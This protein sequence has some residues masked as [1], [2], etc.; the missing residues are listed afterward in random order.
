MNSYEVN[1][2]VRPSGFTVYRF[3]LHTDSIQPKDAE[4]THYLRVRSFSENFQKLKY[5][6]SRATCLFVFFTESEKAIWSVKACPRILCLV[7]AALK[8][9]LDCD[10]WS[11]RFQKVFDPPRRRLLIGRLKR[12]K[13][14]WMVTAVDSS[15]GDW[16]YSPILFCWLSKMTFW[17]VSKKGWGYNA[18]RLYYCWEWNLSNYVTLGDLILCGV[19]KERA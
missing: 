3:S 8:L 1:M 14:H 12:R 6:P 16:R 19:S 15:I 7:T 9:F 18:S 4:A 5:F 2:S 10:L 17:K 13:I 11:S